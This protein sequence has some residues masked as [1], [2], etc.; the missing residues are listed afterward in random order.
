[1]ISSGTSTFYRPNDALISWE[2]IDGEVIAIHYRTGHYYSL[3]GLASELW[4]K[5]AAGVPLEGLRSLAGAATPEQEAEFAQFI[6]GL[7]TG[8]LV[9]RLPEGAPVPEGAPEVSGAGHWAPLH[10][11]QYA[12]LEQLLLADPLHDVDDM[13]WPH[14]PPGAEGAP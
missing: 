3:T 8:G 9:E 5:M 6:A 2:V 12:D 13:G 4:Q 1:M 10:F 7:E 14:L 11:E